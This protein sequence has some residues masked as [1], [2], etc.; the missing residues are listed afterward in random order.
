MLVSHAAPLSEP[1]RTLSLCYAAP[2]SEPR[3]TLSLSHA[4]PSEPRRTLWDKPHP[5]TATKENFTLKLK[6]Q[7]GFKRNAKF[8]C[9]MFLA[10]N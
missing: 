6:S 9:E 5:T 4:A 10:S 8:W 1:R 3:R 7:H 2:S